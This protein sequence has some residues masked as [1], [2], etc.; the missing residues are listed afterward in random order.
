MM[1]SFVK[2]HAYRAD[3]AKPKR[4]ERPSYFRS[5]VATP[6]ARFRMAPALFGQREAMKPP[7]IPDDA[8]TGA[9][10]NQSLYFGRVGESAAPGQSIPV[11]LWS[12]PSGQE[13]WTSLPAGAVPDPYSGMR[14]RVWTWLELPGRGEIRRCFRAEP[15]D[16]TS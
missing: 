12:W 9:P 2:Q 3:R 7:L 11:T 5:E 6:P 8:L 10:V 14:F 13:F 1:S 15:I 16:E 4:V